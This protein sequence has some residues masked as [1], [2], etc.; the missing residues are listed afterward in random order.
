[1]RF[2][3]FFPFCFFTIHRIFRGVQFL[4]ESALLFELHSMLLGENQSN[5]QIVVV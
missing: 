5:S 1:M 4:V 3:S 2:L